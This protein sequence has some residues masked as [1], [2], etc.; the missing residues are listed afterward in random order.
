[1]FIKCAPF[2]VTTKNTCWKCSHLYVLPSRSFSMSFCWLR[3]T[4]FPQVSWGYHKL[5]YWLPW[6]LIDLGPTWCWEFI[7]NSVNQSYKGGEK[8]PNQKLV[9]ARGISA[10]F[11]CGHGLRALSYQELTLYYA[12]TFI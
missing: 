1:M 4:N 3:I 7:E 9:D 10:C 2:S 5:L 6:L 8:R 12:H 11:V